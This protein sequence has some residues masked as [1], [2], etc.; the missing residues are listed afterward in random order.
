MPALT[1]LRIY[2]NRAE[3]DPAEGNAPVPMLVL[4]TEQGRIR[5]PD[6]LALAPG[7]A[8]PIVAAAM[9]LALERS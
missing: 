2:D 1:A 4:H 7:W 5:N 6:G 3:S 9:K 8:K